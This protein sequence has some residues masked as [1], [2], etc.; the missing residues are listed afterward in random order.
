MGC[1]DTSLKKLGKL[2]DI[3]EPTVQRKPTKSIIWNPCA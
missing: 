2:A 3:D 1:G